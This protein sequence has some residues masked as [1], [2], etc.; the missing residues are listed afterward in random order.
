[1][2][3]NLRIVA[4]YS[5]VYNAKCSIVCKNN[6]QI[7]HNSVLN[8]QCHRSTTVHMKYYMKF[9]AY[10]GALITLTIHGHYYKGLCYIMQ[11]WLTYANCH[12][13][14][15]SRSIMEAFTLQIHWWAIQKLD[16]SFYYHKIAIATKLEVILLK[17][18][19]I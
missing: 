13:V 10:G 19:I 6:L 4:K 16:P 14:L 12:K 15:Q 7:S 9:C 18:Y 11:T 3:L 2:W 8:L 17:G 1:M 5:I